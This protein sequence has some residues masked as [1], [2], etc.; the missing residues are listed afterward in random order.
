VAFVGKAV[1]GAG[2]FR[3]PRRGYRAMVAAKAIE[4]A[5]FFRTFRPTL[6]DQ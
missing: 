5:E 1:V 4:I 6:S 3:E 2:E